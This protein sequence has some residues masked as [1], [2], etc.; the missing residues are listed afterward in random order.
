MD[1]IITVWV[2]LELWI[3]RRRGKC[4][5]SATITNKVREKSREC[6][7]HKPQPFPG[8]KRKTKRILILK[9]ILVENTFVSLDIFVGLM[10]IGCDMY[11][12]HIVKPI[13]Q[14]VLDEVHVYF[15]CT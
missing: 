7:N 14:T 8:I 13:C 5:G 4:P 9:S 15:A 10:A 1:K 11:T 12:V 3:K 2:L 6:H